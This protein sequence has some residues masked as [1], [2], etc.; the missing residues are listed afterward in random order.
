MRHEDK[1]ALTGLLSRRA[2]ERAMQDS[3]VSRSVAVID[4]DDFK[5]VNDEHGHRSATPSWWRWRGT[6]RSSAAPGT[7]S[8]APGATSS[9]SSRRAPHA[10]AHRPS[11]THWWP[12][13]E[14][15]SLTTR[16]SP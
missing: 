7:S 15:S 16:T 12:S 1:D 2:L 5:R 14:E 11:S 10:R 3:M 6:W 8:P 13:H 4:V 9:C